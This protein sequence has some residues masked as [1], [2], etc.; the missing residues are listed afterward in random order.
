MLSL[1]VQNEELFNEETNEF[2]ET[3]GFVLELEHSLVSL[4]KWESIFQRPFLGNE[5]RSNE[6]LLAYIEC[7]IL[8]P[9]YPADAVSTLSAEKIAVIRDYINSPQSATTFGKMPERKGRGE[10]I[11]SELIYYW[12]VAFEIPF[13]VE[14]WHLNRLI[15][16]VKVCNIKNSK[17]TKQSK[18]EHARNAREMNARRKAELGTTG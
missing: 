14:R 17:P 3:D 12:L 8:N 11:T 5:S 9:T 15:A 6:E 1:I 13:E 2:I 7:M 4:S 10:T 16:L 18:A